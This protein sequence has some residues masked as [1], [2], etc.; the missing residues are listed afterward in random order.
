M[1]MQKAS[2]LSMF[3]DIAKEWDYQKNDTTPDK[4]APHSNK[5]VFWICEKGHSWE[6]SPDKRARG[7]GCPTCAGRKVLVGFNDL[8]TTHPELAKDWNYEKNDSVLPTQVTRITTKT[9]W[10][11]CHDCGHEWNTRIRDRA[12]D[13]SG[14]T[15]C[16]AIKR[17]KARH[18]SELQKKV[19]LTD[20]LLLKEWDYER[21][22]KGPEE[23]T[24]GS[25]ESVSWGCSKCGFHYYAKIANKTYLKRGC[26][27][28][29]NLVVVP[30]QNDLA[31]THPEIAKEWDYEKNGDL[32]PQDVVY[33]TRRSVYWLCPM[34]HS[35]KTGILHRT[36]KD[37]ATRCPVCFSGRQ[38]SF[39]EQAVSYYV[40]KLYPDTIK[41]YTAPFLGRLELDTYIPSLK[42]AIEYDGM[43][44]HK[45]DKR[46]REEKKYQ[47]CKKNG[48]KLYRL[49]EL[50]DDDQHEFRDT[51]DFAI[52]QKNM[53][54]EEQLQQTIQFLK[55][56][57]DFSHFRTIIDVN[58]KRDRNEILESYKQD[59]LENSLQAKYP[60][61]AKEWHP[62]KNGEL[63]PSQFL[64]KSEVKVWWLCPDCGYEYQAT[65]SHRTSGCG[66]RLCGIKKQA[67]SRSKAVDMI[68]LQTGE[69][70]RT[71]PSV[72]A[73]S[74]EMHISNGN[75]CAVCNGQGRSQAS[76]Y[77]WRY[78]I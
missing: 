2:F 29:A 28:C 47:L 25:N 41:R 56:K 14:C 45:K 54:E 34:G 13:G 57:I 72:S 63:K 71:F 50:S 5:K 36:A 10:W 78:H 49:I 26:P 52:W 22:E 40:K 75:I 16:A 48:I 7:A 30:G 6:N 69:A 18:Q 23:Y 58:V 68:D 70:I 65:P 74:S 37:K 61:I 31:T 19:G 55:E 4:C 42:L 24:R 51:Y 60:K 32:K 9:V 33:G 43:A 67:A 46:A 53:Y 17:G 11:K 3:P 21:N 44:W 20:P 64:P 12:L 59:L 73:A 27:A 66:C 76:G 1:D 35:Y 15:K 38:T 77:K 8:C 62:A 39:A